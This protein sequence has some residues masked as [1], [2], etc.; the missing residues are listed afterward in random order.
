M[1]FDEKSPENQPIISSLP[2]IHLS[3]NFEINDF[4]SNDTETIKNS[5]NSSNIEDSNIQVSRNV[6]LE[7]PIELSSTNP[8]DDKSNNIFEYFKAESFKKEEFNICEIKEEEEL[9]I[10]QENIEIESKT[11][12]SIKRN[13]LM[14]GADS[15]SEVTTVV[16]KNE[17]FE[18]NKE[19][20]STDAK[21]DYYM[22]INHMRDN[23]NKKLFFF[24]SC[25]FS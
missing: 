10:S 9:T 25:V 23:N 6:S 15:D 20:P 21:N 22:V 17:D 5:I 8:S 24:K 4:I 18:R 3:K 12:K 7:M 11:K 2:A 1:N 14:R 19:K 16:K 13:N